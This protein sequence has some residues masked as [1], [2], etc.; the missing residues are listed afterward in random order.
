[1]NEYLG[2]P[3]E[4]VH[5]YR[6][7]VGDDHLLGAPMFWA[8]AKELA[9]EYMADLPNVDIEIIAQREW[10]TTPPPSR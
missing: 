7:R 4:G 1:M 10:V 9:E 6:V 2:S 8:E 3:I 5:L